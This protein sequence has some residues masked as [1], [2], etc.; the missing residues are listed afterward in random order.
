MITS[1]FR[2][3]AAERE[4]SIHDLS[5][6]QRKGLWWENSCVYLASNTLIPPPDARILKWTVIWNQYVTA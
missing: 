3:L 4:A 5:F 1:S 2:V 6:R